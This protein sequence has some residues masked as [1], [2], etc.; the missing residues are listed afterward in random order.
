MNRYNGDFLLPKIINLDNRVSFVERYL[1]L[2]GAAS[3]GGVLSSGVRGGGGVAKPIKILFEKQPIS[4]GVAPGE[5]KSEELIKFVEDPFCDAIFVRVYLHGSK[6]VHEENTISVHAGYYN[7]YFIRKLYSV[8]I[9]SRHHL[10]ERVEGNNNNPNTTTI[11]T[12]NQLL[13][14]DPTKTTNIIR[15][16]RIENVN[17]VAFFFGYCT[18]VNGGG[19]GGGAGGDFPTNNIFSTSKDSGKKVIFILNVISTVLK[20]FLKTLI[21]YVQ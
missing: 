17:R 10:I 16:L 9:L 5:I 3:S 8:Y 13:N 21:R 6:T 1:N 11:T 18:E 2:D 20:F 19:G 15:Y 7:H 14:T 4:R 12:S